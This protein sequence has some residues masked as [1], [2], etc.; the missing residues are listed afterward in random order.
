MGSWRSD[1]HKNARR[2]IWGETRGMMDPTTKDFCRR[3]KAYPA[4]K[5]LRAEKIGSE[6][7]CWRLVEPEKGPSYWTSCLRFIDDGFGH[8]EVYYRPDERRWRTPPSR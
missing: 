5:G 4:L 1:Q 8:W 7:H 3:Q 2:T 6:I